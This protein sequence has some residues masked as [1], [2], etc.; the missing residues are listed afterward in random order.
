M[1]LIEPSVTFVPYLLPALRSGHLKIEVTQ[2]VEVDGRPE[3]VFSSNQ[4]FFIAGERYQLAPTTVNSLSPPE[5]LQGDFS[6]QLPHVVLNN[7][8][9][10]WQRSP[11]GHGGCPENGEFKASW[12]AI[13]LFDEEDPPPKLENLTLAHLT[14]E[15][16]RDTPEIFSLEPDLEVG[17]DKDDP[18]TVIDVP[19]NL[20]NAIAPSRA[21]LDWNAHV[22]SVDSQAKPSAN[23]ALPVLDYAVVVGNR[24]PV[25]GHVSVAHL[26]SLENLGA[27]LPQA[28][29]TPSV[30]VPPT[31]RKIRLVS[32]KSWS[33]VST[34]KPQGL[35][36]VLA[37]IDRQPAALQ[38]PWKPDK[39]TQSTADEAVKL[40]FGLGYTA[41]NHALRDG[42]RSVSWY[43]GPLLPVAGP[44]SPTPPWRNPDQRLC[45]DPES[46]LFDV[47]YSAAWQVG[48]QLALH[49]S[50][51]ASA[52]Y[53]WKLSHTQ[54]EVQ[55]LEKELLDAQLQSLPKGAPL[56][57]DDNRVARVLTE[58]VSLAVD[59]LMNP[60]ENA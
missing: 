18:V 48:R 23:G 38:M 25:R 20:F 30:E 52:L 17:E 37:G 41:L 12:L 42:S 53:R 57:S 59:G 3:E 44:P 36:E 39:A 58:V 55:A 8:S 35:R 19:I 15:Q 22:R 26:V 5:G 51:F 50:S 16:L 13:L 24:L 31:A 43:R 34:A 7:P 40:A 27:C 1:S 11:G 9:L 56:P 29:G 45:Y 10:P 32:L 6:L 54:D 49:D 28:D 2:Q 4:H 21:D 14:L 60:Q 47:S 46:G 33:F